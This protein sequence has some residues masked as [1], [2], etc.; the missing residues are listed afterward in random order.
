MA[1]HHPRAGRFRKRRRPARAL[2]L[3]SAMIAIV[4][5]GLFLARSAS[6][7]PAAQTATAAAAQSATAA[8]QAATSEHA[9]PAQSTGKSAV[10]S[11]TSST[12]RSAPDQLTTVVTPDRVD[13]GICNVPGV[14]DIGGLIGLCQAGSGIPS[15]LDNVCTSGPPAP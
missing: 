1:E 10:T 7:A 9:A 13:A 4:F 2:M 12:A 6:A 8:G 11:T 5:S 3:A 15:L 14:G